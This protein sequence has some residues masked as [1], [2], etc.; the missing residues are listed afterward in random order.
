M[1]DILSVVGKKKNANHELGIIFISFFWQCFLFSICSHLFCPMTQ[2]GI[3]FQS[4]LPYNVKPN[5]LKEIY[6]SLDKKTHQFNDCQ[7]NKLQEGVKN[8]LQRKHINFKISSK[9]D[10]ERLCILL[11]F[12]YEF[13]E[14]KN[15]N[16]SL[17]DFFT[18]T[19]KF[20]FTLFFE[21]STNYYHIDKIVREG[22]VCA[23]VSC[24]MIL[25]PYYCA[26]Y[27]GNITIQIDLLDISNEQCDYFL[28]TLINYYNND[29]DAF[30]NIEFVEN[31]IIKQKTKDFASNK[32]TTFSMDY[33]NSISLPSI[34]K[35]NDDD[36]SVDSIAE[37]MKMKE[38][39]CIQKKG[40]T[41][42]FVVTPKNF[43]PP[44]KNKF[45]VK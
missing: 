7:Y 12:H 1:I 14:D 22:Y 11:I 17:E 13:H 35:S 21:E 45:N 31:T 44:I 28:A 42:Y 40:Q 32:I 36:I 8:V 18:T 5:S 27:L 20:R 23:D 41:L 33:L 29:Y 30:N 43:Q 25:D 9:W 2:K 15:C 4:I 26:N 3:K 24:N 37:I 38:I 34:I 16:Y 39:K 10:S 6:S 19:N